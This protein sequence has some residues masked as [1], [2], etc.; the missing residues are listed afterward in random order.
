MRC[1][2]CG[3]RLSPKDRR[4]SVCGALPPS[5]VRRCPLC[6]YAGEGIAYFRRPGHLVLLLA[7]S[8]FTWG[9]GGAIYWFLRRRHR[10]CPQCGLGGGYALAGAQEA[11]QPGAS[12][13]A[14][15]SRGLRRRVLGVLSTLVAAPVL[16]LGAAEL[17]SG[18]IAGASALGLGGVGMFLWGSQA[19]RERRQAL[20]S[21]LERRVLQLATQRG[22]TLTVTDVAASLDLSL[23]AAERILIGMDDGFRVRSE[24]SEEGL[25]IFEFPEA[26]HRHLE[27]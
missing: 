21:V 4:C 27:D 13:Q 16:V 1:S 12:L 15:P 26:R 20:R 8:A 25:L 6:G 24:I 17:E 14:L 7:V 18:V 2:S 10:V 5:A 22:G 3:E 11:E 23:G 9:M 19:L